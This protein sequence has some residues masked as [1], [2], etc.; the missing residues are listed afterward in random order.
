[1]NTTWKLCLWKKKELKYDALLVIGLMDG[2]KG[3]QLLCPRHNK[4]WRD[5]GDRKNVAKREE[6]RE[7]QYI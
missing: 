7:A 5:R 4:G 1:M 3:T 6:G 2:R